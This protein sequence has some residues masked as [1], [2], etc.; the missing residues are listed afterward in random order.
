MKA[1][2]VL[3]LLAVAFFWVGGAAQAQDVTVFAAASLTSALEEVGEAFAAT[4]KGR[5]RTSYASSS[6]LARQ[7]EKGAP[8]RIFFSADL[9]WMDYLAERKLVTAGSRVNLLGND[10]VLVAPADSALGK[11][12]IVPGVSMT[13]LAG[14]GRIATGDPDHVPVGKYAKQAFEALGQWREVEPRLARLD[15][16]RAALAMVERGEVPLGVVYATDAAVAKKVKVLAV[17]PGTLHAPV[18]YPAALVAGNETPAARAFLEFLA[19]PHAKGIFAR[20]GFK[21]N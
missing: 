10:L 7:I 4:G 13:A 8:A 1:K 19:S 20:H 12:T 2:R 16:A 9:E 5:I 6:A 14:G 15:S 21:V 11:V 17:F 3:S 18:V